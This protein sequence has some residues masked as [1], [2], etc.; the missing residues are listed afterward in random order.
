VGINAGNDHW[1]DNTY[2]YTGRGHFLTHAIIDVD[3][4]VHETD[5]DNNEAWLDIDVVHP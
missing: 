3:G 5:E 2:T 4:D 1:I